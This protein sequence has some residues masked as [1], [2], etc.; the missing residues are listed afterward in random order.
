MKTEIVRY[1]VNMR[2]YCWIEADGAKAVRSKI[3]RWHGLLSD[4]IHGAIRSRVIPKVAS[5][6]AIAQYS[7]VLKR[8]LKVR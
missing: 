3:F 5:G 6:S 1:A 8:S 7:S 2:E 4:L